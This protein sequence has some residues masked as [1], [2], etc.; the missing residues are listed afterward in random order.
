MKNK[1]SGY[2]L[3]ISIITLLTILVLVVQKSYNNLI[4]PINQ[5]KESN[6]TKTI[7]PNLD[8]DTLN[9]IEKREELPDLMIT[10]SL[11]PNPSIV[12]TP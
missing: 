2:F 4:S 12:S 8:V 6:L 9:G 7:N 11:A 5:A 10:P 3:F 1:I